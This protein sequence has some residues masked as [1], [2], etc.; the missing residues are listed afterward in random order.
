LGLETFF[1]APGTP[2]EKQKSEPGN[3]RKAD[4]EFHVN[5]KIESEI[6]TLGSGRSVS[7]GIVDI[8]R[9]R[10]ASTIR[11]RLRSRKF[12]ENQ[13]DTLL[14]RIGDPSQSDPARSRS[15]PLDG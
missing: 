11:H 5:G 15:M 10:A 6:V 13:N 9:D 7:S 1:R 4:Q 2:W 3:S 12:R 14:I 8:E